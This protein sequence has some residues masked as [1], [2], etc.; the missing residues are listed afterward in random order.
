MNNNKLSQSLNMK[1][2]QSPDL[3]VP[4]AHPSHLSHI[5][6]CSER[7]GKISMTDVKD[8]AE[9]H[10]NIETLKEMETRALSR[11]SAYDEED[12]SSAGMMF[13]DFFSCG[14]VFKFSE[15]VLNLW[16]NFTRFGRVFKV[17]HQSGEVVFPSQVNEARKVRKKNRT[18]VMFC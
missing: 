5:R 3:L 9:E 17:R 18:G 13:H 14:K 6:G 16:K 10:I 12:L 11:L 7:M 4:L 15:M 8:I 1:G 2:F